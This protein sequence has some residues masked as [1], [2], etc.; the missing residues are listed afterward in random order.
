MNLNN[1]S[2]AAPERVLAAVLFLLVAVAVIVLCSAAGGITVWAVLEILAFLA[3]A[4]ALFSRDRGQ[5]ASFAFGF[6]A[7]VMLVMFI[8][9]FFVH[10][11]SVGVY[12]YSYYSDSGWEYEFSFLLFLA[13][14]ARLGAY[15]LLALLAF[16]NFMQND[17]SLNRFWYLPALLMGVCFILTLLA[18]I[19][20]GL[21]LILAANLAV[22]ATPILIT[23][24]LFSALW[25]TGQEPEGYYSVAR[26]LALTIFTFGLWYVV[27]VWHTT[28]HLNK[29]D[30]FEKRGP[31]AALLLCL[32]LPFY[33]V[34]WNYASAQRTDRLAKQNGVESKLDVLCLVLGLVIGFLP[35]I[36][37]QEKFN[38]IDLVQKGVFTPDFALGGEAA[39]APQ[40]ASQATPVYDEALP[41]L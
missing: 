36:L 7:L 28:R 23:P 32:F 20:N 35:S 10:A 21:E 22:L 17:R 8:R 33:S 29:V 5:L 14:L 13:A 11:Y 38:R 30:N 6:L 12:H 9:G 27:W 41:E 19:G 18:S 2:V 37:M 1:K 24:F 31:T 39:P 16:N 25:I 26:H 3:V 4:V 34:Y 40:A 15:L